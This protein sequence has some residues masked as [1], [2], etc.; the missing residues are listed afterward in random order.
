MSTLYLKNRDRYLPWT[1]PPPVFPKIPRT[2][3]YLEVNRGFHSVWVSK[4][5]TEE[6]SLRVLG[7][8]RVLQLQQDEAG[9]L[10][11]PKE[12]CS[13]NLRE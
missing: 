5:F 3:A 1:P 10:A 11:A 7:S 8:L 2:N 13:R 12:I 9:G 6:A 4:K